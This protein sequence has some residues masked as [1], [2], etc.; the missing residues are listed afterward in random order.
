MSYV[1]AFYDRDNDIIRVVE[2]DDKG[3]RHFK[4]YPARHV[5]YYIDPRG[6]FT[7]IKGEPLSRVSS[8]NVKEH[9]KELAIHSNKK[10]YESDINP[11][12]RCLEDHYL[13]TDAPKL[14]VA[15]FD[16]EVDFDPERGY[17][18]PEDAFM[19]ITAIAVYLQWMETMICLAI[20]PKTLSMAE[21]KRQ[22]EDMPNTM[23]FETESE[24][25]D[26]F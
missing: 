1:D 9:R 18:S 12:Y 11:I 22:V 5:F 23:L 25:L 3:Q 15:F 7:S 14:N 2:R 10:L 4:E 8:K 21:A 6:K 24:M 16:I 19:P 20:P 13:N 26:T 17:A